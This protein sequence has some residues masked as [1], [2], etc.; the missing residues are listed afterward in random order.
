[1]DKRVLLIVC[2]FVAAGVRA[3]GL[4]LN[5][6]KARNAVRLSGGELK[7][8]MSGAK[9]T[10]KSE[11]GSTRN[12]TNNAD[13][14]FIAYNDGKSSMCNQVVGC[15]TSDRGTWHLED[16]GTYCVSIGWYNGKIP[17]TW[18]RYVYKV[19]EKYYSVKSVADGT[20]KA[21]EFEV[22]K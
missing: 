8:V 9:I 14:K 6:L 21:W 17:E 12:W 1:M 4:V 22:S 18:C 16:N 15:R 7:E 2:L 11:T 19:G 5:D 3:E 20:S 10:T 13:G